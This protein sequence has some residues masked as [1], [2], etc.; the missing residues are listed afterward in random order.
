LVDKGR[1]KEKTEGEWMEPGGS[2]ERMAMFV[3]TGRGRFQEEGPC[4]YVGMALK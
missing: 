1:A 2:E 3:P 4:P